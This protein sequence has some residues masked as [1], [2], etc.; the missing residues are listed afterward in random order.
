MSHIPKEKMDMLIKRKKEMI[1]IIDEGREAELEQYNPYLPEAEEDD[2]LA[3]YYLKRD[4][5]IDLMEIRLAKGLTQ[6]DVAAKMGTKQ[7]AIS[8]FE[9]YN[10]EPTLEFMF[11]YAR[12]L[13]VELHIATGKEYSITLSEADYK[14]I[15]HLASKQGIDIKQ[16]ASKAILNELHSGEKYQD[17]GMTFQSEATPQMPEY[18]YDRIDDKKVV[19]EVK[20]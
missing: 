18:S 3:L 19:L 12:A 8:R 10:T 13:R 2:E 15:E 5:I 14:R 6:A 20:S 17:L 7:T 11:K 9:K 1:K 16:Y 4:I